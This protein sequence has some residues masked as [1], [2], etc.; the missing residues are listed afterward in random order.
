MAW[1]RDERN[2]SALLVAA[3]FVV[4]A[5]ALVAFGRGR[6]PLHPGQVAIAGR[7]NRIEYADTNEA[8]TAQRQD[9][10]RRAAP[11]VYTVSTAYLERL[12]AAIEGLPVLLA[13]KT[14]LAEVPPAA[15]ERF[16]L[17]ED[18]FAAFRGLAATGRLGEWRS[19]TDRFL[20]Q[21][22]EIGRAHV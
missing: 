17:T 20:R 8:A 19:W 22:L 21:L 4:V 16:G 11:R 14:T 1:V 7:V 9:D 5:G 18:G 6:A 13:D 10:A 2:F 15:V 3:A 12:H